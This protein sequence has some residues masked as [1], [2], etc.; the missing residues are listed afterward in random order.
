MCPCRLCLARGLPIRWAAV[1]QRSDYSPPH[2]G[3]PGSIPGRVPPPPPDSRTW[4]SC[5]TT[6]LVGGFS[7]GISPV[8]RTL[9][10]RSR[11]PMNP[12]HLHRFSKPR[13]LRVTRI[14]PLHSPVT[15]PNCTEICASAIIGS[16]ITSARP[17][18]IRVQWPHRRCEMKSKARDCK[19]LN[20][21]YGAGIFTVIVEFE[22]VE[23]STRCLNHGGGPAPT[24]TSPA[25]W[26]QECY[27]LA[28]SAIGI[29]YSV[30]SPWAG[31]DAATLRGIETKTLRMSFW[32]ISAR[33]AFMCSHRSSVVPRVSRGRPFV[34]RP[35]TTRI[36]MGG[37]SA[38]RLLVSHQDEQSS[39]PGQVTPGFSQ[40]RIVRDDTAGRPVYW[41]ISRFPHPCIPAL[42]HFHLISPLVSQDFV[43][44][45]RPNISTQLNSKP[46]K[47]WFI[48]SYEIHMHGESTGTSVRAEPLTLGG[49]GAGTLLLAVAGQ[50]TQRTKVRDEKVSLK[51]KLNQILLAARING[52]GG[53]AGGLLKWWE[54]GG[55]VPILSHRPGGKLKYGLGGMAR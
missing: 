11:S 4:E 40:V 35:W 15:D 10:L 1:V 45:S 12:P 41:E 49:T 30:A 21:V 2:L 50:M 39:I 3:E 25:S 6:P 24:V 18:V 34:V 52:E 8:S 23:V 7:R 14:Y 13:T 17:Q 19:G 26:P 16:Y 29:R 53:R 51:R 32:G 20:Y 36:P 55:G 27:A 38:V 48:N 28:F 22:D 33:A 54:W 5:R 46:G 9:V 31:I 43:V 44:K 42:L 37:R 47:K